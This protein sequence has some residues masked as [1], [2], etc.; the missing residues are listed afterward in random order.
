[1]LRS[2]DDDGPSTAFVL[3]QLPDPFTGDELESAL[4]ALHD[5]LVTRRGATETI[6]R[7]RWVAASNYEVT[8]PAGSS[9][10]QRVLSPLGPTETHGME[11]ARFVRFVDDDGTTT[12]Y[13][14]YTAYDG[15]HVG[16]QLLA[17]SDFRTFTST[18]LTGRGARNK[19]MALFPRRIDGRY[20]ALSRWDR[21]ANAIVTSHDPTVWDDPVSPP[22]ADR[23]VGSRPT[24][25]LRI[26]DRDTRRMDHAHPRRRTDAPLLHRRRTARPRRPDETSSAT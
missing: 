16:S 19:G 13:A 17:T 20:V 25:Q 5:Q 11:D 8:F 18:Q 4:G 21:E 15:A 1:M 2:L 14:T 12:Y 9:I 6:D 23:A 3:D 26:T 10:S 24:R 22:T 7:M